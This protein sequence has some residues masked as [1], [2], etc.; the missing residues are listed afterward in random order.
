VEDLGVEVKRQRTDYCRYSRQQNREE[1][2][3][4]RRRRRRRGDKNRDLIAALC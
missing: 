4:R 1:M 3:P 2:K